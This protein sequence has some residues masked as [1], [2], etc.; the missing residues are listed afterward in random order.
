LLLLAVSSLLAQTQSGYTVSPTSLT[1]PDQILNTASASRQFQVSVTFF[2]QTAPGPNLDFRIS[3]SNPV[4]TTDTSG[5][6][7]RSGSGASHTVN[8]TF[9]PN[10][11]G[12]VTG[13]IRVAV[14][15]L[16][17]PIGSTDVSVSGNGV[18]GF[19]VI[20]T[21]LRFGDVLL[22][23]SN[24]LNL[25]ILTNALLEFSIE[26]SNP[27]FSASP[28]TFRTQSGQTVAATFTPASRGPTSTNYTITAARGSVTAQTTTVQGDGSGVDIGLSLTSL[29]FGSLPVGVA[30]QP[31]TVAFTL[32]PAVTV[33]LT[34]TAVSSERAFQVSVS[35]TT[36]AVTFLPSAETAYNGTIT[37]TFTRQEQGFTPCT[38]TRTLAVRGTGTTLDIT[39]DP[40]S[41]DFGRVTV[42]TTSAPRTTTLNNRAPFNFTG[43]ASVDNPAFTVTPNTF[44]LNAGRPQ[45]F[46][47]TFRPGAEGPVSTVLNLV[48]TSVGSGVPTFRHTVVVGISA[49]GLNPASLTVSPTTLDFG[50]VTV[51]SSVVRSLTVTNIGGISAAVTSSTSNPAFSVAPGSFTLASQAS[52]MVNI[53][54]TPGASGSVSATATFSVSGSSRAVSL[55]GRGVAPAFTYLPVNP[56]GSL[57]FPTTT[58][59]ATSAFQQFEIRNTGTGSATVSSITSSSA[60]FVLDGVPPL[61]SV[62]NAG[63]SISFRIAFRPAAPGPNAGA[64]NIDGRSFNLSGNAILSGATFTG[65]SGTIAAATQPAIGLTLP[66]S[67][68]VEVTGQLTL[69]FAAN[70]SGAP[71]D[72]AI[73]FASGGRTVSFRVPPGS[74]TAQFA[75]ATQIA[76]QSGTVAGTITA[77]ATF[78]AGGVEVTPT[79]APTRTLTIARAAPTLRALSIANRTASSFQAVITAFAVTREVNTLNFTFAPS[80]T[81]SLQTTSLQVEATNLFSTWYRSAEAAPHGGAFTIT[82]P[83]NVQGDIGAIRSLS[84]TVNN[85]DGAS[86][87]M[88]ANF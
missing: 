65:A 12:V 52:Q 74:T 88:S 81:G 14:S 37:F 85:G 44:N 25:Q 68:P 79:T 73:Q 33:N 67:Y 4:F 51:G 3:S 45:E 58:L 64:L 82:V 24:T 11:L 62:V 63:G 86:Q 21:L 1:F 72:P 46:S 15:V 38:V 83:F 18:A 41:I 43:T 56:G 26:S 6:S 87:S 75:N 54:F 16:G 17:D 36:A 53:T 8:V 7:L 13:T 69:S 20:P 70:A 76:F 66:G 57:S 84:V 9:T 48:L 30:S 35:G 32:N 77:R 49:E 19:S 80:G 22:G 78:Q 5:F 40:R 60:A 23:C 10:T 42:G 28:A 39:A 59:G 34:A 61:P 47:L 29:D 71:D 2:P 55:G 50:D 31:R 27:I